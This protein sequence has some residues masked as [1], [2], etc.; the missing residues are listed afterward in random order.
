MFWAETACSAIAYHDN[1]ATSAQPSAIRC[2]QE[3]DIDEQDEYL[4][5][6]AAV[7][8]ELYHFK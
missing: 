1:R 2:S 7:I 6:T 8:D 3:L 4:G 5:C